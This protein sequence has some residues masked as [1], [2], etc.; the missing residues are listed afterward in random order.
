M[1]HLEEEAWTRA[2]ARAKRSRQLRLVFRDLGFRVA[3]RGEETHENKVHAPRSKLPKATP[4]IGLL[5]T[6][7]SRKSIATEQ[8]W[9][10]CDP[11]PGLGFYPC[12]NPKP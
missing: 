4:K 10:K 8:N 9:K 1:T 7:H 3:Y 6:V 11:N 2:W 12:L 5:R